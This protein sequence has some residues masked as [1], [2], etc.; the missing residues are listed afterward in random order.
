MDFLHSVEFYV[1][2]FMVAAF[3]VALIA[4][5]QGRG[6]VETSFAEGM[7]DKAPEGSDLSPRIELLCL[8]DGNVKITRYGLPEGLDSGATVALALSRKG[9]DISAEERIT[10]VNYRAANALLD[11]E[12]QE[13]N[14]ATFILPG[15][16]CER[17][18]LKY[19]SDAT[20]SFAALT[21]LN[22]PGRHTVRLFRQA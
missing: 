9:F 16:A 14:R 10:A 1:I 4:M 17:Y 11:S 13:V 7:L 21:F 20:S 22:T 6:P 8:D 18:H 5:P 19:N 2:I 12:R 15:L 3:A